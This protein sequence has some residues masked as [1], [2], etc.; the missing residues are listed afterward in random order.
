MA[1]NWMKVKAVARDY[2]F[3]TKT[4][5]YGG[6]VTSCNLIG[7]EYHRVTYSVKD[8]RFIVYNYARP[9]HELQ[10]YRKQIDE[11]VK[12]YQF[13]ATL[14]KLDLLGVSA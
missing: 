13:L 8:N 9:H 4:T 11:S 2:G 3:V 6:R 5:K 1:V 7:L 14:D 12:V 10:E